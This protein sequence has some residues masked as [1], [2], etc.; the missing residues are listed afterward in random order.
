MTWRNL[1][2]TCFRTS[3]WPPQSLPL[4]PVRN[5]RVRLSHLGATSRSSQSLPSL[6]PR[7]ISRGFQRDNWQPSRRSYSLVWRLRP[8]F[9]HIQRRPLRCPLRFSRR[10][11]RLTPRER[12][13]SGFRALRHRQPLPP[14]RQAFGR[15]RHCLRDL[16]LLGL[17]TLL[18]QGKPRS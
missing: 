14:G 1:F 13:P 9:R 3:I 8:F 11:L 15:L 16:V 6:C 10:H 18:S 17:P 12:G 2:P 5:A 7:L 4:T